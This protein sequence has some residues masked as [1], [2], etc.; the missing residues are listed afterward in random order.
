MVNWQKLTSFCRV[1]RREA[2]VA[3]ASAACSQFPRKLSFLNPSGFQRG[4]FMAA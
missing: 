3:L 4:H 2:A 1:C